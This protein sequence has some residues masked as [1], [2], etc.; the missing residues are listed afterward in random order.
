M[1]SMVTSKSDDLGSLFILD[2][3]DQLHVG[4]HQGG[5]AD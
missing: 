4:S 2:L 3:N 5:C 1:D